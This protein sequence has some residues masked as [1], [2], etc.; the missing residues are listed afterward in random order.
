MRQ[1]R[2]GFVKARV[3]GIKMSTAATFTVMESH[4]EPVPGWLESLLR[5]LQVNP[6]TMA[7]PVITQVHHHT[8]A[9]LNPV[10]QV[11]TYNYMFEMKWGEVAHQ[12]AATKDH[13]LSTH[14]Y[15]LVVFMQLDVHFTI[16]LGYDPLMR[17]FL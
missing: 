14:Q 7:N 1:P 10:Y 12:F 9:Q 17:G 4:S 8:F 5:E 13:K 15:T 16:P 3:A 6:R 11:M 2:E